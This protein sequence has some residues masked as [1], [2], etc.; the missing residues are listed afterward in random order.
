M[1]KDCRFFLRQPFIISF[2]QCE[3]LAARNLLSRR[4]SLSQTVRFG[5]PL[6][7]PS[8]GRKKDHE[9]GEE[10]K[11]R[12]T[13]CGGGIA[14]FLIICQGGALATISAPSSSVS[15]EEG[16]TGTERQ[17]ST[18]VMK[19]ELSSRSFSEAATR[20]SCVSFLFGRRPRFFIIGVDCPAIAH[21]TAVDI[22]LDNR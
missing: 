12:E 21:T 4:V 11:L 13:A 5:I 17:R 1:K 16:G 15:E 10:S 9:V 14:S 2:R 7:P 18:S 3:A 8:V 20:R 19:W 22:Q 6:L